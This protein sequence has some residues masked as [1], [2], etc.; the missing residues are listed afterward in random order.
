MNVESIFGLISEL[1]A[2]WIAISF[3]LV[4]LFAFAGHRLG[5]RGTFGSIP[6]SSTATQQ[7][8]RLS[9]PLTLIA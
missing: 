7:G 9:G 8:G 5:G 2:A 3:T 4:A 6:R 1:L